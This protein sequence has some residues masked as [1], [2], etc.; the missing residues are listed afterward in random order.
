MPRH[1]DPAKLII[2]KSTIQH[3]Q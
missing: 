1:W 3:F 2:N